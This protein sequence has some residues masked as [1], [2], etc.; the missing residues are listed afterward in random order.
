MI[1]MQGKGVSCG[2]AMGTV[3]IL[4]RDEINVKRIRVE[5]TAAEIKRYRIAK[6]KALAQLNELYKQ[7]L[8]DLGEEDALIFG[9]HCMMLED[10]DYNNSV[11]GIIRRQSVN[12]EY[13]VSLTT[14]NLRR[15]FD[16][17]EDDYIRE[18]GRAHV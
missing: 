12:A 9:M 13:A 7:A 2:I 14:E 10:P 1:T 3:R 4:T 6:E 16:V 5:D 17:M 11:E 15:L 8:K 18:I